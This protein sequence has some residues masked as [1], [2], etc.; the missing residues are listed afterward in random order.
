MLAGVVRAV[1]GVGRTDVAVVRA[2]GPV[3]LLGI[4]RTCLPGRAGAGLL[5]VALP[6]GDAAD[7]AVRRDDVGRT[8]RARPVAGLGRVAQVSRSGPAD[9][10][11]DMHEVCG[12]GRAASRTGLR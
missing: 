4:R 12:T 8:A 11:V 3:R 5:Q 9:E 1:A 10:A 2:D 7:R 6:S